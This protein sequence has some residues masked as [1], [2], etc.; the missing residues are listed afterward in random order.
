M[1]MNNCP[2]E[3]KRKQNT[4]PRGKSHGERGNLKMNDIKELEKELIN[5]SVESL[6]DMKSED[7]QTRRRAERNARDILPWTLQLLS[8]TH[9]LSFA[10]LFDQKEPAQSE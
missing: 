6:R 4:G 8:I 2:G 3:G 7:Y 9:S 5:Y 1:E 10:D